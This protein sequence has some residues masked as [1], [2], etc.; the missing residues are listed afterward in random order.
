MPQPDAPPAHKAEC[1][2]CLTQVLEALWKTVQQNHQS[3]PNVP[4]MLIFFCKAGR[5]RSYALLIAF[6]R[7]SSHIHE[8]MIWEAIIGPG[9]NALL[10]KDYPCEL[11]TLITLSQRQRSK[12][13]GINLSIEAFRFPGLDPNGAP[14]ALI[15]QD[16]SHNGW[17]LWGVP[18]GAIQWVCW[19][20]RSLRNL[21]MDKLISQRDIF[22]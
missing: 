6:L 21:V 4:G 7:W 8:V 20:R 19:V 9:R 10:H 5:H 16:S 15:Q 18:S 14:R 2:K 17:G 12:A 3:D 13:G 11:A 22:P 1:F